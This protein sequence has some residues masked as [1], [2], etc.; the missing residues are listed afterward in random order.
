MGDN[1]LRLPG[2]STL[3]RSMKYTKSTMRKFEKATEETVRV[4]VRVRPFNA[5]ELQSGNHSIVLMD[6]GDTVMVSDPT[7]AKPSKTFTFDHAYWSSDGFSTNDHGMHIP[8]TDQYA[9]QELVYGDMGS[10]I[11]TNALGGYN[12]ALFAY[13]QTGSGKSYT[14][15][16]YG[17]NDGVIPRLCKDLFE[18]TNAPNVDYHVTFSMLEIYNERIR[19]LLSA[20]GSNGLRLRQHPKRGFYV[21]GLT[22]TAVSSY[23]DVDHRMKLGTHYRTTAQTAMNDTSSRS[24]MVVTLN[25]KQMFLNKSGQSTTKYSDIHLVD[26]AGSERAGTSALE[27][28]LK[29]GASINQSLSTLGNVIAALAERSNAGAGKRDD[30]VIPYRNSV[31]TKILRNALGGNSKT[32]MLATISPSHLNY[33]ETMST[34]RFADRT[35]QIKTKAI[36]NE[37]PTDKLIRELREENLK[38]R[39][40]LKNG[41]VS[42]DTLAQIQ[43]D[44]RQVDL[45]IAELEDEWSKRLDLARREWETQISS[46]ANFLLRH[47]E[48]VQNDCHLSNINEDPQLSHVIKQALPEGVTMIGRVNN[49]LS[50]KQQNKL[51]SDVDFIFDVSGPGILAR[52]CMIVRDGHAISISPEGDAQVYVNGELLADRSTRMLKHMDRVVFGVCQ[53]FLFFADLSQRHL[54]KGNGS[55]KKGME[56][57]D[58]GERSQSQEIMEDDKLEQEYNFDF[59]QMEIASSQGVGQLLKDASPTGVEGNPE[60]HHLRQSLLIIAPLMATA[61]ALSAEMDKGV[62]FEL[63]VKAGSSHSLNDSSK[64]LIVQVTNTRLGFVWHWDHQKFLHRLELMKIVYEAF[65]HGQAVEEDGIDAME[66]SSPGDETMFSTPTPALET[67]NTEEGKPERVVRRRGRRASLQLMAKS[68]LPAFAFSPTPSNKLNLNGNLDNSD[69]DNNITRYEIGTG[70]SHGNYYSDPFWDPPEDIFLGT[71]L[72]YLQPLAYGVSI[73]ETLP[74]MDYRGLTIA[75]LHMTVCLCDENGRA[76]ADFA[77]ISGPDELLNNRVDILVRISYAADIDWMKHDISRGVC[78]KYRFYTDT[79]MRSTKSVTQTVNPQFRYHKQFT[80]KTA[81]D[82]FVNYLKTNVVLMELWGKQG[83][84][85]QYLRSGTMNTTLTTLN[86]EDMKSKPSSSRLSIATITDDTLDEEM[87]AVLHEA[88][89]IEERRRL[90]VVIEEL[91]QEIDFLKIEKGQLEKEMSVIVLRSTVTSAKVSA[92]SLLES[93]ADFVNKEQDLNDSL[94]GHMNESMQSLQAECDEL[95]QQAN[96]VSRTMQT[97]ISDLRMKISQHAII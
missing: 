7:H 59:V 63:L 94:D 72:V 50:E 20:G 46:E 53:A 66:N 39:Q 36:V 81:S 71:A 83:D 60:L 35:K 34:L 18:R 57:Q 87:E 77:S 69:V 45:D 42:G 40:I 22:K 31:L 91:Q 28:R 49:S 17:A 29:E 4:G 96:L 52:H 75:H 47:E 44:E 86:G 80:I 43:A 6:G 32:F 67:G 3:S 26:L 38:L 85:K 54:R 92:S 11:L 48:E 51:Y 9:S 14:M 12:A 55:G 8:D 27:D 23:A 5:R 78:C 73:D 82:N 30:I 24:H 89:W 37:S 13:G 64:Q 79:K 88:Q 1:G 90:H 15:V 2:E 56:K 95:Q 74:V 65:I 76:Y 10:P 70:T 68:Q 84:G 41:D 58:E 16:G 21:D 33:E 61:N 62:R 93:T 19:D 25:I 97:I